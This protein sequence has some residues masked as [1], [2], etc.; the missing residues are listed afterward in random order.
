MQGFEKGV[1]CIEKQQENAYQKN[2]KKES[3]S[4]GKKDEYQKE[5]RGLE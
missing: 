3:R 4:K 5:L 2:K 1:N